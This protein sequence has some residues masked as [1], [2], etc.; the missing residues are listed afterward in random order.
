MKLLLVITSIFLSSCAHQTTTTTTAPKV[1]QTATDCKFDQLKALEFP[2]RI[3]I[4]QGVTN[5]TTT[6]LSLLYAKRDKLAVTL[7]DSSKN[8]I[9]TPYEVRDHVYPG[10]EW[11]VTQLRFKELDKSVD[12]WLQVALP[13]GELIDLR[14]LKTLDTRKTEPTLAIAAGMDD[15]FDKEQAG[16]WNDLLSAKPDLIFLIGDNVYGD[17]KLTSGK[18][19]DPPTLW[20]RYIE[21]R[22]SLQLYKSPDLVPVFATWDDRDFGGTEGNRNHIY[23]KEAKDTF[24][25]FFPQ[26]PIPGFFERGPGISSY[27]RAF[28]QQFVLADNRFF[29]SSSSDTKSPTH[30]G[31]EQEAWI[32]KRLK[33]SK[34]PV[35]LVEGDQYFGGYHS[36]E[37]FEGKH[38]QSFKKLLKRIRQL[39]APAVFVSGNRHLTELMQLTPADVGYTTYELTTSAIH[40]KPSADTWKETPN[41]RKI[42]G[43]AG[44]FNYL[45]VKPKGV[46]PLTLTVTA[47]GPS[48]KVLYTRDLSITH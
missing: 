45:I 43:T 23:K 29:R 41:P 32:F 4:L 2:K 16:M 22:N 25:A 10:I 36:F 35:W 14:H 46:V 27:F 31:A 44:V 24:V 40:A 21:T 17:S 39:K 48:K 11:R 7:W 42:E 34:G 28:G 15:S 26:E 30:W 12:Y 9:I 3:S 33:N 8:K 5:D 38:P 47:F 20:N 1:C 37:S 6:Q 13:T 18:L 19:A